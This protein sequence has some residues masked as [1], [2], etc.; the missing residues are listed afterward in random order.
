M[1][2]SVLPNRL[3]R[4]IKKELCKRRR[5]DDGSPGEVSDHPAKRRGRKVLLSEEVDLKEQLYLK[6]IK[7]GVQDSYSSSTRK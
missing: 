5:S 7:Q 4:H 1:S 6:K 3:N 2:V